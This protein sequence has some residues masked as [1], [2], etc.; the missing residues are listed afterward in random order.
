[1]VS[2]LFVNNLLGS[3]DFVEFIRDQHRITLINPSFLFFKP[4][5]DEQIVCEMR[6][7]DTDKIND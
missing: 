5:W 4:F 7:H 3:L 2:S 1:M 6:N